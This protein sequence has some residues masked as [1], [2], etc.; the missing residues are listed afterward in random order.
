M[1][2]GWGNEWYFGYRHDHSDLTCQDFRSRDAWWD[3]CRYAL[4]FF[5]AGSDENRNPVPLWNMSNANSRVGGDGNRCLYGKDD[6]G[7]PCLVVQTDDGGSFTL[8]V[9]AA[10]KYKAGWMNAKT[11]SWQYD[12]DIA[13]HAGG[14]IS[15][16]A[17]GTDDWILLIW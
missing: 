5:T 8:D 9:P 12:D 6:G 13:D 1:A 11:G 4:E 3:Y 15:F 10:A 16:T 17:P 14:S 2:G 7:K